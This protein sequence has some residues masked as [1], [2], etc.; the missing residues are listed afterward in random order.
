MA[1]V[2]SATKE[3]ITSTLQSEYLAYLAAQDRRDVSAV[4]ACMSP[5][6]W[7]LARQDP[8]W[9]LGSRAEIMQILTNLGTF[10][11]STEE[12]VRGKVDMRALTLEERETLPETERERA[13]REGWEGLRVVLEDADPKGRRVVVNYYWRG[14]GGWWVQCL[15]DLLWVG[16][17]EE[18]GED[19]GEAVF[20]RK[21]K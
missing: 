20:G 4:E 2:P 13:E 21:G 17:R 11:A 8:S 7:Q 12:R 10:T 5:S 14:E 3:D 1:S 16:P 6:C 9:N 19:V 18:G 15:H